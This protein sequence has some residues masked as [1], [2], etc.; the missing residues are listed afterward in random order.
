MIPTPTRLSVRLAQIAVLAVLVAVATALGLISVADGI[1]MAQFEALL[2]PAQLIEWR[3][4]GPLSPALARL[5]ESD[6]AARS[7]IAVTLIPV[8]AGLLMGGA[9]RDGVGA[10]AAAPLCA[11]GRRRHPHRRG[12]LF[13]AGRAARPHRGNRPLHLGLRFD[14]RNHRPRSH[15]SC[16]RP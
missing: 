1:E 9:G 6:Y 3:G 7:R 4:N 11:A 5:I 10:R 15:T 13:R 12:R 2:T 16:V 14:G 8:L